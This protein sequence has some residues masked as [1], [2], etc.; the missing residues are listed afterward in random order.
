MFTDPEI[1][2][3]RQ[4]D[5][6]AGEC[7][8]A[9]TEP[10]MLA[11]A[12]LYIARRAGADDDD[13]EPLAAI[14]DHYLERRREFEDRAGMRT[15]AETEAFND[16]QA[17]LLRRMEDT[18]AVRLEDVITKLAVIAEEIWD[19]VGG[20]EEQL[21]PADCLVLTLAD[22]L[23]RVLGATAAYRF[24]PRLWVESAIRAGMDPIAMVYL[25]PIE[26]GPRKGRGYVEAGARL[27]ETVADVNPLY[28]PPP[29]S[30]DERKAV[31]EELVRRGR[32]DYCS[33]PALSAATDS[34]GDRG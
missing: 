12:E 2:T 7:R 26:D 27:C 9:S 3:A 33:L 32:A 10:A 21:E 25:A 34:Q 20:D 5:A 1:T 16:G 4:L 8:P 17:E 23:R 24:D 13:T 30:A 28:Q 11:G 14:A 6:I 15:D 31:I 29:L 19:R 18:P 22:D